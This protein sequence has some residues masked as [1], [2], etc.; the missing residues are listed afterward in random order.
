MFTSKKERAEKLLLVPAD[1]A[2]AHPRALSSAYRLPAPSCLRTDPPPLHASRAPPACNR[3]KSDI[4]NKSL[5]RRPHTCAHPART[6]THAARHLFCPRTPAGGFSRPQ[7]AMRQ[8]RCLRGTDP[9]TQPGIASCLAL[10]PQ[11]M[12]QQATGRGA[13]VGLL[14]RHAPLDAQP[15]AAALWDHA[16][17]VPRLRARHHITCAQSSFAT[18][19]QA[20]K[21]KQ[22]SAL[23][24]VL[25]STPSL[26]PQRTGSMWSTRPASARV[27]TSPAFEASWKRQ[28]HTPECTAVQGIIRR[29]C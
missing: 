3:L 8:M 11:Q 28:G 12:A 23:R 29:N 4:Y 24:K 20:R 5:H 25:K 17:H 7:G 13:P 10:A 22:P 9:F 19:I 26:W 27:T 1:S 18:Y 6:T 16:Q 2:V 15:V 21:Y 14:R